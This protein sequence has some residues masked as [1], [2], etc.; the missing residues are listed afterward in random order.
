METKEAAQNT[1]IEEAVRFAIDRHHGQVRKGTDMPYILH[2]L[3]VMTILNEMQAEKE[4]VIAGVLHDT[5][6]D[7]NTNINEIR[8]RFGSTVADLVSA[9]TEDKSKSWGERK[10]KEIE[11]IKTGS[12]NLQRLILADKL[13]NMRSIAIDYSSMGDKV[14]D[15]FNMPK[16]AQS[17]YY[18]SII[19]ELTEIHIQ[20]IPEIHKFY[21]EL[22]DLYKDVFVEFFYDVETEKL[23]QIA[24]HG[25]CAYLQKNDPQWVLIKP[26][27][28]K[29]L[30][31][32][33]DRRYAER[34]ED[35]WRE[36][37]ARKKEKEDVERQLTKDDI[38]KASHITLYNDSDIYVE[39]PGVSSYYTYNRASE[40]W[41]LS[42]KMDEYLESE[43]M[44][45][46]LERIT[47]NKAI[48][49]LTSW[50]A[51]KEKEYQ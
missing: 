12:Y 47:P 15:R 9:H 7:T 35:N 46:Y 18:S 5:V 27:K 20:H 25:E 50:G 30:A 36:K 39:M 22:S 49:L 43:L 11:S 26:H 13:S 8:D 1:I 32:P 42:D 51:F 38:R 10:Q 29:G 33:V 44:M 34:I 2:P 4:V 24:K 37:A 45:T 41:E 21:W 17:L 6:E 28:I 31:Y 23:W 14:F 48:K 19:D 16:E 40:R 3:E